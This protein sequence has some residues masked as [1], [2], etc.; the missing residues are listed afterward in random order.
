MGLFCT[1][2]EIY[3]NFSR[4][5]Q[6]FPIYPFYFASPLQRFPLELGNNNNNN[7]QNSMVAM[8]MVVCLFCRC[9]DFML[10]RMFL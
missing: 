1:V 9:Q 5:S 2:S 7:N 3:G 6:N 4:K 10:F 8:S